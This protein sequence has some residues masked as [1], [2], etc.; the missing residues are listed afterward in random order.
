MNS[1]CF[2]I[3]NNSCGSA[4]KP[5]CELTNIAFSPT[6]ASTVGQYPCDVIPPFVYEACL[7][8][9]KRGYVFPHFKK[10]GKRYDDVCRHLPKIIT[11]TAIAK[12]AFFLDKDVRKPSSCTIPSRGPCNRP[13]RRS[14]RALITME[15]VVFCT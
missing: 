4:I 10:E 2:L 11:V 3:E 6:Y 7:N 9:L 13:K 15:S 14:L 5:K 8:Y 12:Q 1:S